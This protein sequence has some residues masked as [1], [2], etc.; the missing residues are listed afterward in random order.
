M[1]KIYLSVAILFFSYIV[2]SQFIVYEID[3]GRT[4]YTDYQIFETHSL[5]LTLGST[6]FDFRIKNTSDSPIKV[7]I[8]VESLINTT[9]DGELCVNGLCS[10]PI[11]QGDIYP[12][13]A[14]YLEI[15]P[16]ELQPYANGSKWGNYSAGIDP[17]KP[18][19]YVLKFYQIN[20][21]GSEIGTPLHVI[22][23]YTAESSAVDNLGQTSDVSIYPNPADDVLTIDNS[24]AQVTGIKIYDMTGKLVKQSDISNYTQAIDISDL[25]P[26]IFLV[27][28]S[29]DKKII[30]QQKLIVK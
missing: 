27:S 14:D 18:A 16:G 12:L 2:H 29:G 4:P 15:Q 22:C 20:N 21:A 11:Y 28:L 19:D 13:N 5:D 26:G 10:H 7:R 8:K 9:G 23:R 17:S 25:N 3:Q 6:T 24:A 1:K 30:S